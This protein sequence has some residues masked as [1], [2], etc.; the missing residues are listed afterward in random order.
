[1][2]PIIDISKV[3]DDE[4]FVRLDKSF[5]I[6]KRLARYNEYALEGNTQEAVII[7]KILQGVLD[8]HESKRESIVDEALEKEAGAALAAIEYALLTIAGSQP[9]IPFNNSSTKERIV[10][11]L[12][13]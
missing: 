12:P 11:D 4:S 7:L 13:K 2:V 8:G 6:A 1:M 9:D 3:S 10:L 5:S